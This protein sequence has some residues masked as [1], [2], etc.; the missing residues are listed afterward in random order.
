M[1][2]GLQMYSVR[3]FTEKDLLG[4]LKK[5]AEIGYK[6]IEFAGFF[7]NSAEDVKAALDANGLVC[8]GTHTGLGELDADFAAAVK[9]HHTIGNK[10]FIIPWADTSTKEK[11]DAL[12]DGINKYQPMLAAEGITLAFHNHSGEFLPNKDGQIP[13]E[14]MQKRTKI[15]FEID[16]CWANVGGENPSKYVLKY[17]GRAPVVHLKDFAGSKSEN[18]YELI[19]IDKKVEHT[20]TFEFRP[21]GFGNQNIPDILAASEKAGAG[22]VVVEQ[23]QPSMG[24][25]PLECAKMSRDYLKLLGW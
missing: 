10:N 24:K 25:T 12:I 16:T 14:E 11:L 8:S 2:Y 19:G 18:M 15:D 21:V 9:Y 23:D 4:T 20:N 7:G 13:H 5:V 22:W 17:T 3:D 6:Y 1:E